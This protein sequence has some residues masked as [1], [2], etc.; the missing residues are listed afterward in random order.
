VPGT[1]RPV[2]WNCTN[3]TSRSVA[4]AL[5]ASA[6][7]SP[8]ACSGFVVAANS[9]PQPPVA[10]S[11]ARASTATSRP[12]LSTQTPVTRPASS[13]ASR[14]AIPVSRVTLGPPRPA[15]P[16]QL[17]TGRVG[18]PHR[19]RDPLAALEGEVEVG[20]IGGT[21]ARPGWRSKS[22]PSWSS[23]PT[24]PGASRVSR[25]TATG[26][27][28]RHR[29]GSCPRRAGR[30]SRRADGDRHAALR[31]RRRARVAPGHALVDDDDVEVVRQPC[32]GVEAGHPGADDGF[33]RSPARRTCGGRRR[34]RARRGRP[35]A[36]L[37]RVRL[38]LVG[39]GLRPHERSRSRPPGAGRRT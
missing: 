33:T 27:T 38:L 25:S 1:A 9:P 17:G 12:R 16:D 32:G 15:A 36:A 24:W 39:E 3:S 18:P 11:T 37:E 8:V 5:A 31:P 6:R 34:R 30:G 14:R 29:P 26:R 21:E 19:A 2:G 4:P 35:R 22:A 7:P 28:A 10:S 13:W 20:G 23:S